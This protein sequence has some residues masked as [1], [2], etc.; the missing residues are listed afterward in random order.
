MLFDWI[1]NYYFRYWESRKFYDFVISDWSKEEDFL[2]R[3]LEFYVDLGALGR[4]KNVEVQ[5]NHKWKIIQL[6]F[7]LDDL[8]FHC[9]FI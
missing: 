8:L 1:L 6:Q 9:K 4:P 3:Q 5:V 7:F 2:E